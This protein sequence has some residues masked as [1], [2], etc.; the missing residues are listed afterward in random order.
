MTPALFI[1]ILKL[2]YVM[3]TDPH[4]T[5]TNRITAITCYFDGI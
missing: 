3:L 2:N 1:I 5:F 4:K